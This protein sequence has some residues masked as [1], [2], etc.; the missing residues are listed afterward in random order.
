MNGHGR[1]WAATADNIERADLVIFD[2]DLGPGIPWA[3]S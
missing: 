3:L 1:A 2:L